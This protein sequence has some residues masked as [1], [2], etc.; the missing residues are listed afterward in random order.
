MEAGAQIFVG[1]DRVGEGV[2]IK[3][4]VG[5]EV[6]GRRE[7][8]RIRVAPRLLQ[9]D[10][11]KRGALHDLAHHRDVLFG[12]EALLDVVR[13]VE[14]RVVEQVSAPTAFRSVFGHEGI[15]Q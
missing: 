14:M 11:E 5:L 10:A 1:D 3:R 13:Q 6:I 4:R 8:P 9:R 12:G 15:R 7:V 2:I